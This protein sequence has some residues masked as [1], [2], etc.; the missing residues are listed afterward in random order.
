M[1]HFWPPMRAQIGEQAIARLHESLLTSDVADRS[2]EPRDFLGGSLCREI[3]PTDVGALGDHQD[4]NARLGCDV[5]ESESPVVF[6]DFLA[7]NLAAQ[8]LREDVVRIIGRRGVDRHQALRE[9]FSA[10]PETPSRRSSSARTSESG[11]SFALSRTMRWNITS[12][13][14]PTSS[15]RLPESAAIT[16]STPSSPNLRAIVGRPRANRLAT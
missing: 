9:A 14:S 10:R 5:V 2:H 15:S 6:V 1:R 13:A 3:V 11:I 8:N 16:V 12:A 7:R 4:V